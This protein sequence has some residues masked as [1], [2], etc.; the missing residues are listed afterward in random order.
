MRVAV[1][2]AGQGLARCALVLIVALVVPLARG[3]DDP[4]INAAA[5]HALRAVLVDL[6][7]FEEP[8]PDD[9]ELAARLLSVF[10]ELAPRDAEIARFETAAAFRTGRPD[11]LAAATAR[12]VTLDP[13]DTV[14][15]LRLISAR[16]ASRQTAEE[17]L[18]LYER[19]LGEAGVSI[20][21]T[22]RSRLALDAAMIYREQGDLN[23]F[24]RMLT[25][26][27]ELDGTNKEAVHL[28]TSYYTEFADDGPEAMAG[29]LELQLRLMWADPIDP[30]VYFG[31]SRL[32]AVEGATR[33]AARFYENGIMILMQA[34]MIEPRHRV[35]SLALRWLLD[36]PRTVL[37]TIDRELAILRDNARIKFERDR[38]M[39]VP[40]RLLV[41]PDKVFLDPL[42]E[43]IRV[44]AAMDAMDG[45]AL[46]TAL[47]ELDAYARHQFSQVQEATRLDDAPTRERAFREFA[48]TLVS[49]QF[50]R[51]LANIEVRQMAAQ[52]PEMARILGEEEWTMIRKPLEAW[53]SLRAGNLEQ[54]REILREIGTGSAIMRACY[55]EL[56]AAE[57]RDLEAS[58]EY[59]K[60]LRNDPFVPYGAW[61]RSRAMELTGRTDP[62]TPA[63]R[64]MRRLVAEVP[65]ALDNITSDPSVMMSL[66]ITPVQNSFEPGERVRLRVAITNTTPW[67]LSIGPNRTI[68]S[69]ILLGVYVDNAD[70]LPAPPQPVVIDMGRRFRIESA[71]TLVV[72]ARVE[73][74]F[75][76]L[77]FDA[78][79]RGLVRQRWQ[80]FQSPIVDHH[81]GYAA[82]PFALSDSTVKFARSVRPESRLPADEL[83]VVVRDAAQPE[84]VVAAIESSA[85]W[86][87]RGTGDGADAVVS[88]LV[89]R[90]RTA[91]PEERALL[92]AALP[93]A[94]Q[95]P[96][97]RPF[98]EAV[99]REMSL[100]IVRGETTPRVLAA[101]MLFTR[102][103]DRDDPLLRSAAQ[104]GDAALVR[105]AGLLG[106]RLAKDRPT[107]ARAGRGID[108]LS[109]ASKVSVIRGGSSR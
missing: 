88:A 39:D 40:D 23:S 38:Q 94:S 16:V 82:G 99:K 95:S 28:A 14:A 10:S 41:P 50:M 57:G 35:Q 31:I 25:R 15:Q 42:Y 24:L 2:G 78:T 90:Y 64:L 53:L 48:D 66:H 67:P 36:G 22:V 91:P 104:S 107:Y 6:G 59:E 34:G 86:L 77:V 5:E 29:L 106:D 93:S 79:D 71:E 70:E 89:E 97:M 109:G 7:L 96:A 60:V 103:A 30:N 8:T 92:L 102:V 47:R 19:L 26:A 9:Y 58:A 51:A 17:R 33:E 37:D 27:V 32:L 4:V 63:G 3:G 81:G 20:H 100:E 105:L 72:E 46:L 21:H 84:S 1:L 98:D 69:R 55:A 108:A 45:T 56:L 75:N 87:R 49:I 43:K 13:A 61:A 18:A 11:M 52:L 80:G 101:I 85:A 62:V 54:T 12:V 74:G 44:I 83:A 65:A 68:P 76:G 73:Q